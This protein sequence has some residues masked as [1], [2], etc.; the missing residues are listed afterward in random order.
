MKPPLY[1][2]LELD[3]NPDQHPQVAVW[4]CRLIP[5]VTWVSAFVGTLVFPDSQSRSEHEAVHLAWVLV[6]VLPYLVVVFALLPHFMFGRPR[7]P[8]ER[9]GYFCFAGFTVGLGPVFWYFFR[10]D[11]FWRWRLR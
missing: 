11:P 8:V 3:F 2:R 5:I 6:T 4:I 10:A 1:Q 7:T 9:W